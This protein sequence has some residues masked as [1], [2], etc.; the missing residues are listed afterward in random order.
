MKK[1]ETEF[2]QMFGIDYPIIGAPMFLVSNVEMVTAISN[3]GAIGTFPALNFRPIEKYQA[4]LKEITQKTKQPFG[5]NIIVNKSNQRQEQDL[6]FA[7]ESGA[8][9][10]RV[11]R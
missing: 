7:L 8:K 11:C 10:R 5:V 4:A 3:A 6:K 9:P 1:I 2:T